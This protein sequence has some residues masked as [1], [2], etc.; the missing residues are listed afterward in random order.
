MRIK[1]CFR[2]SLFCSLLPKA[3]IWSCRTLTWWWWCWWGFQWWWWLHRWWQQWWWQLSWPQVPVQRSEQ[4]EG[5]CEAKWSSDFSEGQI[6][7]GAPGGP[8]LY[9]ANILRHWWLC[10]VRHRTNQYRLTRW[11]DVMPVL[12]YLSRTWLY[13]TRLKRLTTMRGRMMRRIVQA[14]KK[15]ESFSFLSQ[16]AT[17]MSEP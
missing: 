4:E 10:W 6:Q 5:F 1:P 11:W 9:H 17:E 2:H 8:V 14:M 3:M 13:H 16:N 12:C 7:T 15:S